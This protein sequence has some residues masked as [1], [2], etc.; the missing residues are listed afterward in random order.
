MFGDIKTLI[1]EPSVRHII[2][3]AVFDNSEDGMN[4][5]A[6]KVKSRESRQLYAWIENDSIL[7]VCDYEAHSD[8][9]EILT[10]AVAENARKRGVGS[11]MVTALQNMYHLSIEAETDDDAVGFYRK[12]GFDTAEIFKYDVRRW[13]C[14]LPISKT[15]YISD[16]DGTLLNRNA[17]LSEYTINS[18]NKLIAKGIYFSAATARTAATSLL[19]LERVE[20][21]APIILMNGVLIYDIQEKR[22]VKKEVLDKNKTNQIISVMRKTELTGLMYALS[23][24]ALITY[25][26]N[27]DNNALRNFVEERVRKYNKR[28]IKIDNFANA[29]TEIIYF[30][31]LNTNDNI[32]RLHNAIKDFSGIRIELYQD[33]YSDDLWYM[34]VFNDTASKY[35]AVQFL[36]HNYGFDKIIGFGDNLNDISLFEACD[37]CYAVANAKPEVKEKATTVI[38]A[39][40]E[41]GVAKWMEGN[42]I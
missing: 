29:E 4:K 9:V 41:D 10:I 21:N 24:D 3:A 13:T 39:N 25:Y 40:D 7:G 23:G 42:A 20:I 33:I 15:L 26:E 34:E 27:L 5:W 37:E 30:C 14:I 2:S 38:G 17:E 32:H 6:E 19:M 22:Y 11:L 36:R 16:L 12:C 31:F 8:F 1:D 28:F 35:N 18:L